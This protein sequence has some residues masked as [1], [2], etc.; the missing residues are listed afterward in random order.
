V[1]ASF[2]PVI[3]DKVGYW[4]PSDGRFRLDTNGNDKWDG[5]AGGDTL[6][7]AFGTATD[8]PVAGDWTGDGSDEVGYWRPSDCK[9]RLDT[10]GNGKWDGT[11]GGD[12]LTGA[13]GTP[14][15]LPVVG[16]WRVHG[17]DEVGF[18]RPSD[19]KLRLDTAVGFWRPSDRKFRLDTNGNGKWDGTAGGD[20]LTGAFGATTDL[21]VVGDWNGD[22]TDEVGFWRPSD[23]K[24]RLDTNGNDIWNGPAGG[25][26]LTAAFGTATD[27]PVVGDWNGDGT[28]EVG[29]WR[30][31][32]RKFRLDT[33]GNG[34]WDGAAGGDTLT[35]VFGEPTD[36]PAVG[37]W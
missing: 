16:D 21:P 35:G 19:R 37:A 23:R 33:N 15:D 11:A 31:S 24:F 22:G 26:T 29:F 30:P 14:T 18:W 36:R 27:L 20:T 2:T 7:N 12:T 6:T 17:I 3:Y 1:V 34:K 28:D 32:D 13:F 5:T 4:R 9:F 10:N 8:I 25:D